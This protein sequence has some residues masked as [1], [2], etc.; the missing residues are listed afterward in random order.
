MFADTN[1]GWTGGNY[2]VTAPY[3]EVAELIVI[4]LRDA[5]ETAI[6]RL[7]LVALAALGLWWWLR[8]TPMSSPEG[9]PHAEA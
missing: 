6:G 2:D 1:A 5:L 3:L 9:K 4:A 7:P 8:R